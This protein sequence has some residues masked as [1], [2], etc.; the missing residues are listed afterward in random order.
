MSGKTRNVDIILPA[1]LSEK[2][3]RQSKK[4]KPRQKKPK[5]PVQSVVKPKQKVQ[6]AYGERLGDNSQWARP[7]FV[8]FHQR[9]GFNWDPQM[10][11]L[12]DQYEHIP[13]G[14][15]CWLEKLF[16]PVD[17]PGII[18]DIDKIPDGALDDS[19]IG[20]ARHIVYLKPPGVTNGGV[21][22]DG[23]NWSV[24]VWSPPLLRTALVIVASA[25][26]ND[27]SEDEVNLAMAAW[28][29]LSSPEVALNPNWVQV[30]EAGD[31]YIQVVQYPIL[32]NLRPPVN[33]VSPDFQA[34]RLAWDGVKIEWNA[35]ALLD[36]GGEVAT[37]L[38]SNIISRG[39]HEVLSV[40]GDKI[41]D[42]SYGLSSA[43]QSFFLNT[44]WGNVNLSTAAANSSTITVGEDT[45]MTFATVGASVSLSNG[46]LLRLNFVSSIPQSLNIQTAAA[47]TPTVFTTVRS[48]TNPLVA[49][50]SEFPLFFTVTVL[51]DVLN[52]QLNVVGLPA[53]MNSGQ[54]YQA[55]P[56]AVQNIGHFD[57]GFKI[58]KKLYQPTTALRLSTGQQ[59]A[60]VR[61]ATP[62]MTLFQQSTVETGANPYADSYDRN[63]G[64]AFI[65]LTGISKANFPM[66]T[67]RRGI[68]AVVNPSSVFAM[69]MTAGQPMCEAALTTAGAINH[70]IA[71][72]TPAMM[73]LTDLLDNIIGKVNELPL[74]GVVGK[75]VGGIVSNV[76]GQKKPVPRETRPKRR[77][78]RGRDRRV[79][80][81]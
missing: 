62:S 38:A 35:P 44:P 73:S 46:D 57:G 23:S 14:P 15:E 24:F 3:A 10:A 68:E 1:G 19:M 66:L 18:E 17:R 47:A 11:E 63:F 59:Y 45:V 37:Q 16:D 39:N 30:D 77:R 53:F 8:Q 21:T 41:V 60:K 80:R 32:T 6:A 75:L 74:G 31:V 56:N 67:M 42:G 29:N 2:G 49:S 20:E 71:H 40:V 50:N 43:I 69:F 4:Q 70:E 48:V 64:S 28:N 51:G 78:R 5:A 12:V 33:G 7:G 52:Q 22:L 76:F 27:V 36:Q 72:A 26:G 61:F 65:Q 58:A 79:A 9:V 54:M 25:T 55:S 13:E 81:V 34:Y